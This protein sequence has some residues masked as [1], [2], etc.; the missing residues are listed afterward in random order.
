MEQD[1]KETKDDSRESKKQKKIKT[2]DFKEKKEQKHKVKK[3]K[4]VKENKKT[5][6][7][8]YNNDKNSEKVKKRKKNVIIIILICLIILII[9]VI[10]FFV[11]KMLSRK[12]KDVTLELGIE[13]LKVQDF[14][15]DESFAKDAK[16]LT[17]ISTIDLKQVGTYEIELQYKDEKQKVK[18]TISD[19]TAPTVEFQD[20]EKYIDYQINPEDFIKSKSD[21]SEMT[22]SLASPVQISD[23]GTYD[24]T[25][26]V[27]DKYDN[28]TSKTCKLDITWVKE[29]YVLEYGTTLTKD[30]LLY[31]PEKDSNTISDEDM[32]T[33]NSS[34][35]GEYDIKSSLDGKEKNIHIIIQDTTPPTLELKEVTIYDDESVDTKDPFIVSAEDASGEVTTT[36]KTQIDNSIVGTQDVVIEAVDK[37]G[38]KTEQTTKLNRI[39]DTEGPV[40]SGVSNLSVSKNAS[41]DYYSGVTA[42]D[43]KEGKKDFTV[44]SS[45]VDTSKAG[46][47]YAVYTSS[48]SKGNTT[49]YKRKVTVKHD[50]T[51]VASLVK[52]ISAQCGNGVEEIRDFVRKKITYGHSY[53][54]GDPVW[55]GFTNWTGNC[56]VHALCFQAL[57]RDKGYE[58]QLIWTTDKSHYW[59]IVKINGSWKHM[60]STPDRN[61]RKI[62]IMNDEQRLSTLSGR[63]WDRSAWPTAN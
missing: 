57:L 23:Y 63:T 47:Y 46:T 44:N 22:V 26:N 52:E 11:Y 8:K 61:H 59:N 12:F 33:I 10:S 39:K 37:Y 41:I 49:T 35:P 42:R 60:D 54:D 17:D 15:T 24:V 9:A 25:V 45:S 50:S 19:T 27:K 62:S 55:Y 29:N 7:E 2:K 31:N 30:M 28:L 34:V 18:L 20:L 3:D 36:L 1:E 4:K 53:G 56:Y 40:F 32:N 13:E 38:N 21:L 51:D 16:F 58:T 14:V 6:D 48:D 43:A 5:K